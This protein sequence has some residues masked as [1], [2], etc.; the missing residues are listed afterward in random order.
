MNSPN[1]NSE[2]DWAGCAIVVAIGAIAL[3]IAMV[4]PNP[5]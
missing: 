3:L 2:G 5:F 1:N 4:I